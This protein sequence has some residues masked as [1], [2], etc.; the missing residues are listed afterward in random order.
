[1][2]ITMDL[3]I[4]IIP[5]QIETDDLYN[6]AFRAGIAKDPEL[7][8]REQKV[9]EASLSR[10]LTRAFDKGREFERNNAKKPRF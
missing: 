5:N 8:E 9:F 6:S 4:K 7:L 2:A 3:E 10:Y 1:M